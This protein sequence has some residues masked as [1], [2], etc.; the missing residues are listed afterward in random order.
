MHVPVGF[1]LF[2]FRVYHTFIHTLVHILLFQTQTQTFRIHPFYVNVNVN[3]KSAPKPKPDI[4]HAPIH[5]PSLTTT[6]TLRAFVSHL[7][8]SQPEGLRADCWSQVAT[9]I[10]AWRKYPMTYS[11]IID[12]T[13]E[14]ENDWGGRIVGP[15]FGTSGCL[16]RER[17]WFT[18]GILCMETE[19]EPDAGETTKRDKMPNGTRTSVES[20]LCLNRN[21]TARPQ[22]AQVMDAPAPEVLSVGATRGGLE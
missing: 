9:F 20:Q 2:I 12:Y 5:Q 7:L 6:N 10:G 17:V 15:L 19:V 16:T 14:V 11:P 13:N 1:C 4:R 8:Q 18:G 21:K 3:F 22:D